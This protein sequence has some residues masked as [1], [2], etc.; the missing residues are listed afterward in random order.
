MTDTEQSSTDHKVTASFPDLAD[1]TAI[2]TGASRGIGCGI[3]EFLGRQGM[4]V[5]LTARSEEAGLAFRSR[6]CRFL[7]PN[8]RSIATNG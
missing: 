2:V 4:N 1:K 5:V 6:T 7:E 3:A 8:C